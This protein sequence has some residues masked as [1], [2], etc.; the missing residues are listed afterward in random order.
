MAGNIAAA[1]ADTEV[2]GSPVVVAGVVEE[3]ERK[4]GRIAAV[5]KD[6]PAAA[7]VVEEE[8]ERQAERIAAAGAGIPVAVAEGEAGTKA[9]RMVVVVAGEVAI[10]VDEPK[11]HPVA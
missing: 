10:A 6:T 8:G 3:E 9:E 5:E 7:V 1:A 2:E 4:A 11:R